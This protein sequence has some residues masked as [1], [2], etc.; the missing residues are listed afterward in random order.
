MTTHDIELPEPKYPGTKADIPNAIPD[1]YTADQVRAAIEADLKR[2]GVPVCTCKTNA[3][4][5]VHRTD[6]PCFH[7][8]P[9]PAEPSGASKLHKDSCGAQ[10]ENQAPQT[11]EPV[12][13][14]SAGYTLGPISDGGMDPRNEQAEP[15]KNGGLL[16]TFVDEAKRV[17]IDRLDLAHIYDE[18]VKVPSDEEVLKIAIDSGL[19]FRDST[20]EVLCAWREDADISEYLVENARAL[21][22][23]YGSKS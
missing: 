19:A 20:G 1:L 15:V 6:G 2:R 18:P 7:Y 10:N 14:D 4:G 8:D 23:R 17:G 3:L 9:H 12:N 21:L 11:A 5:V 16:R 22:A 13:T